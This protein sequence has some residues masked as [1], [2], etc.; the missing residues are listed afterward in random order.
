LA[1][2]FYGEGNDGGFYIY[3]DAQ[4]GKE[5][6]IFKVVSTDDGNLLL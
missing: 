4:T 5:L 1:Y 2:E 3:V 6:V